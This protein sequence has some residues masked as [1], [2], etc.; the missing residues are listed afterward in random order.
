ME[1]NK[2]KGA[3]AELA[4]AR[5]LAKAGYTVSFPHGD[6]AK[7]DLISCSPDGV[8]KRIQVKTAHIREGIGTYKVALTYGTKV[9]CLY[10]IDDCDCV[11]V[12][13]PFADDFKNEVV[14]GMYVIPVEDAQ[15]YNG[16]FFPPGTHKLGSDKVCEFEKFRNNLAFL[17]KK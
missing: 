13:L 5:E 11:I 9:K 3:A 2:R 16:T 7:F 17:G 4:V 14:A 12:W 1:S 15:V 6:D 10:T 8:T